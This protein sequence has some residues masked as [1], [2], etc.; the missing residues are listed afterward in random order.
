MRYLRKMNSGRS[1]VEMLSVLALIGILTVGG[2]VGFSFAKSKYKADSIITEISLRRSSIPPIVPEE[3]SKGKSYPYEINI[4]RLSKQVNGYEFKQERTSSRTFTVEVAKLPKNVC[5]KVVRSGFN[6]ATILT[7]T[8]GR[9]TETVTDTSSF[10][11]PEDFSTLKFLFSTLQNKSDEDVSTIIDLGEKQSLPKGSD[12]KLCQPNYGNKDKACTKV[13]ETTCEV[14]NDRN[15]EFCRYINDGTE[16]CGK[17][18]N[19][20]C[21]DPT[22]TSY[23]CALS[24]YD[25]AC[26]ANEGLKDDCG[27]PIVSMANNGRSCIKNNYAGHCETGKCKISCSENGYEQCCKIDNNNEET[28]VA[29]PGQNCITKNK[30]PGQCADN[31]IGECEELSTCEEYDQAC[32]KIELGK[33]TLIDGKPLPS[34]LVNDKVCVGGKLKT[35][36]EICEERGYALDCC[37]VEFVP[38]GYKVQ[39]SSNIDNPCS[40]TNNLQKGAC[41][42][43]GKCVRTCKSIGADDGCCEDGENDITI[44]E[45][46]ICEQEGS[47]ICSKCD[48]TG[49][50]VNSYTP[51]SDY[52]NAIPNGDN[53]DCYSK[54]SFCGISGYKQLDDGAVCTTNKEMYLG[55]K[56]R[57][58]TVSDQLCTTNK[59]MCLGG[60]CVDSTLECDVN[61]CTC[62]K[63]QCGEK[64]NRNGY[65]CKSGTCH[66]SECPGNQEILYFENYKDKKVIKSFGACGMNINDVFFKCYKREDMG[67]DYLCHPQQN[68]LVGSCRIARN[69]LENKNIIQGFCGP[70]DDSTCNNLSEAGG[71]EYKA[72]LVGMWVDGCTKTANG[73]SVTCFYYNGKYICS[74]GDKYSPPPTDKKTKTYSSLD[75]GFENCNE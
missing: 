67:S 54:E 50:C 39:T 32:C 22:E 70:A 46:K 29:N 13:I 63:K 34:E 60:K 16:K 3:E 38:E 20:K 44:H 2:I 37:S 45:N 12:G 69:G 52:L 33:I 5:S 73:K 58:H 9:T 7:V 56:S 27:L 26:C 23:S 48:N 51:P 59:E 25:D 11:C 1:M 14:K 4:A 62:G 41:N 49:K 24:G 68:T 75:D 35:E 55:R 19:G 47:V 28:L 61:R 72:N 43:R 71:W 57:S 21:S 74:K 36:K 8:S 30:Y 15:G 40:L 66:A 31:K 42:S 65:N 17:C 6:G 53:D 18:K 10:T 64:C